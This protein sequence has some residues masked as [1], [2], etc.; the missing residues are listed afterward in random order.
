MIFFLGGSYHAFT[1]RNY[2]PPNLPK[3][4]V[5]PYHFG[6]QISVNQ[7]FFTVDRVEN[8]STIV[9]PYSN[10]KFPDITPY[11]QSDGQ[12][13]MLRSGSV[14]SLEAYPRLGFS[15]SIIGNL[16]LAN[17]LNLR[18]IPTLSF[19]ERILVYDLQLHY[20]SSPTLPDPDVLEIVTMKKA[21]TSTFL[22]F[23]GYIQYKAARIRNFAPY[24]FAGAKYAIDLAS[25]AKKNKDEINNK[26]IK[27]YYS[28]VMGDIG[29]GF[30]FYNN[31]FKLGVELK[32]TYGVRNMVRKE[33]NIY[34]DAI[35]SLRTKMFTLG[36]TFE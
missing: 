30:D 4:E 3:Y 6:F 8:M 15:I 33:E 13:L 21:V 17:H 16:R 9:T 36:F 22:E 29:V 18:A 24:I 7:M 27:L 25:E 14:Y 35:E 12:R 23:P 34:T 5:Q 11:K 28:D 2:T 20:A 10:D 31:W 1:Q 19:G 32:M 26:H